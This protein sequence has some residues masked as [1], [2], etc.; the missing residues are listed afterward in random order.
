MWHHDTSRELDPH[1]DTHCILI[2]FISL[3]DGRSQSRTDE[4]LYYNNMLLGQIYRQKLALE[5]RKLGYEIEPQPKE[6]F[7]IKGYTREQIEALRHDQIVKYLEGREL[8]FNEGNTP[9]Q[10]KWF[11][12]GAATLGLTTSITKAR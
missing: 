10:V 4:N 3:P 12:R 9:E 6:L 8:D 5:C 1:L 11:G 7:E 2:N